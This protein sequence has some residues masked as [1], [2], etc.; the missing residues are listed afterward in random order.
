[1][2]ARNTDK[3]ESCDADGLRDTNSYNLLCIWGKIWWGAQ[4]VKKALLKNCECR[5]FL[6]ALDLCLHWISVSWRKQDREKRVCVHVLP[7]TSAGLGSRWHCSEQD[8]QWWSEGHK[9]GVPHG[10]DWASPLPTQSCLL[11][12]DPYYVTGKREKYKKRLI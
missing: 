10:T 12:S 7:L 11:N 1:M 4:L 5:Y 8:R 9:G 3:R 6:L 2:T